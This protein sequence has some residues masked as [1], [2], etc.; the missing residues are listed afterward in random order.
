M[1]ELKHFQ[2]PCNLDLQKII[3]DHFGQKEGKKHLKH[4]PKYYYFINLLY[5]LKSKGNYKYGLNSYIN[6]ES[7]QLIKVLNTKFTKKIIENLKAWG[8]IQVNISK[9]TGKEIFSIEKGIPKSYRLT[10]AYRSSATILVANSSER[11]ER[12]DAKRVL[13]KTESI[14]SNN[15]LTEYKLIRYSLL[16]LGIDAEGAKEALTKALE[17]KMPLEDKYIRVSKGKYCFYIQKKNRVFNEDSYN[18]YLNALLNV[19][20]GDI[21]FAVCKVTNRIYSHVTNLPSFLRPF[22]MFQEYNLVYLDIS[23]SQPFFLYKLLND[24]LKNVKSLEAGREREKEGKEYNEFTFLKEE[25]KIYGEKLQ[26]GK[27]YSFLESEIKKKGIEYTGELK[28]ELFRNWLYCKP[29]TNSKTKEVIKEIFPYITNVIDHLKK[30]N[31]K[32]LPIN[33]TKMESRAVIN[34]ICKRICQEVHDPFVI[35]IH[36]GII[37]TSEQVDEIYNI[38]LEELTAFVGIKPH[39]KVELLAEA[40][41]IQLVP[42]VLQAT[43]P[44]N[45]QAPKLQPTEK[46][47]FMFRAA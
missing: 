2:I 36:D 45:I 15:N 42:E 35:T 14:L 7:K 44:W 40:K 16:K 1:K 23:S 3:I 8:I 20:N 39:I 4:L 6:V 22:I 32:D 31:Y 34:H 12:N 25:L 10:D 18:H 5:E 47:F 13:E 26:E 24:Y 17:E 21:G 37:T 9:E 11:I 43:N 46:T 33:L 30:D 19:E 27:L 38:M 29:T 28:K 41:V